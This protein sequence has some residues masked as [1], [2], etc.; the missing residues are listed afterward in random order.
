MTVIDGLEA[1]LGGNTPE[2][3]EGLARA[4]GVVIED[5]AT[6]VGSE[7]FGGRVWRLRFA[8]AGETRSLIAKQL[9]P[10]VAHRNRMVAVRW[11]PAAGLAAL[12]PDLLASA[13]EACGERVWQIFEDLGDHGLDRSEHDTEF[14]HAAVEA[15]AGLHLS[16]ANHPLLGECRLW[17][18]D[19]GMPFYV[20]NARDGL[21]AVEA[22]VPPAVELPPRS[23]A[24]RGRL[25]SQLS[26]LL[27]EA[28]ERG[29]ALEELGGP[30][31]LVH[32]DLWTKNVF[33]MATASVPRVC[34][35]DWDHAAV[36]RLSY[37]LSTFLIR[38]PVARRSEILSQ[39]RE[40][41]SRHGW[42]LPG[43]AELNDLFDTAERARIASRVVWPALALLR[44]EASLREWALDALAEISAWF[45]ALE[46]VLPAQPSA[47]A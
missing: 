28:D 32:G 2:G 5:S 31:T 26:A 13:T 42:R 36:A 20:G 17:G 25:L 6:L 4:L 14:V 37:D 12:R 34:L 45:E 33:T 21:R 40:A 7:R 46:P 16:F 35:I 18:G 10:V 23:A 15:I 29:R 24:A 11:L 8:T 9:D 19:L 3:R 38:F 44:G 39:Y 27:D 22:L 43:T 1:M 41:V 30:E 47:V